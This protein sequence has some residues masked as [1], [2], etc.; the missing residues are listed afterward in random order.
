[1]K[2]HKPNHP[3][4][5]Q[6]TKPGAIKPGAIKPEASQ[7]GTGKPAA[8]QADKAKSASQSKGVPATSE[9][10]S[11]TAERR[12]EGKIVRIAAHKLVATCAQGKEHTL[13]VAPHAKVCCDGAACQT[14]DLQVG[15][16]IRWSTDAAAS[17]VATRIETLKDHT[18]FATC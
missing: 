12:H 13:T 4:P 2:I 3:T 17:D 6:L 5:E 7:P 16:R 11:S 15:E 18:A 14:A 1:M 9:G 8:P 10:G